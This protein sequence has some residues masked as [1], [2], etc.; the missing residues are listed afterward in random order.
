MHLEGCFEGWPRLKRGTWGADTLTE[1]LL[2]SQNLSFPPLLLLALSLSISLSLLSTT[3][4]RLCAPQDCS[5]KKLW[6][7][8]KICRGLERSP[9]QGGTVPWW[10]DLRPEL[11]RGCGAHYL[12]MTTRC[13]P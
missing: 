13:H 3:P 8:G 1:G 4:L 6:F 10:S 12:I 7:C 9:A 5:S 2:P 11:F